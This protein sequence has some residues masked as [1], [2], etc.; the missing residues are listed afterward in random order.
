M[1]VPDSQERPVRARATHELAA[2]GAPSVH[3]SWRRRLI[4]R[5]GAVLLLPALSALGACYDQVGNNNG[6]LVIA[7]TNRYA[8]LRSSGLLLLQQAGRR[9]LLRAVPVDGRG[10]VAAGAL[11][12]VRQRDGRPP[13]YPSPP[14]PVAVALAARDHEVLRGPA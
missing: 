1:S 6:W 7:G 5:V 10:A 3:A 8:G 2:G 9:R 14:P 11:L 13:G 4:E 12:R